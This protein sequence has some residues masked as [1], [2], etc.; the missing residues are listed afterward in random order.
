MQMSL[1]MI[2]RFIFGD[3]ET[4]RYVDHVSPKTIQKDYSTDDKKGT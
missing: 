1:V 2:M 3:V 4:T